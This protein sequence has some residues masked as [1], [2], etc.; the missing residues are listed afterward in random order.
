MEAEFLKTEDGWVN[1]RFVVRVGQIASDTYCVDY[2]RGAE[3]KSTMASREA[4]ERMLGIGFVG[5]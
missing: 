1:V 2:L 3:L 5:P 4:T